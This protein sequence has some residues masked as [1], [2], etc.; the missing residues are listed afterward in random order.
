MPLVFRI[1]IYEKRTNAVQG[2]HSG[3]G[4]VQITLRTSNSDHQPLVPGAPP[5]LVWAEITQEGKP[6]RG[7]SVTLLVTLFSKNGLSN[8]TMVLLDDGSTG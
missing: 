1:T 4:D 8:F 3:R 7:A 6:V 5:L 2:S